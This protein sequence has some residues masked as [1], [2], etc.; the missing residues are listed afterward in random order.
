MNGGKWSLAIRNRSLG[1]HPLSS[2]S[3]PAAA[4]PRYHP[5]E[6]AASFGEHE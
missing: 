4:H 6:T 1:E 3:P 2:W 5:G